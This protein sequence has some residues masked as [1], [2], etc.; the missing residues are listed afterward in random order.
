MSEPKEMGFEEKVKLLCAQALNSDDSVEV[1]TI[2]G[3]LRLLLH[4]R[5]EQLRTGLIIAYAT[6]LVDSVKPGGGVAM[7]EATKKTQAARKTPRKSWHQLA[8]EIAAESDPRR[9]LQLSFELRRLLS[10]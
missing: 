8:E 10:L 3:E 9:A 7:T 4:R 1:G 6:P 5:I 2:L